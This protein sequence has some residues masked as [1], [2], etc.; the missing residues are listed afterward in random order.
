MDSDNS[1]LKQWGRGV[2]LKDIGLILSD[3][4]TLVQPSREDSIRRPL[5]APKCYGTLIAICFAFRCNV[6]DVVM[7]AGECS[8]RKAISCGLL[9]NS[10]M[11]I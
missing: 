7:I 8:G 6:N 10:C 4:P 1:D 11:L 2:R 3:S 9:S 5:V